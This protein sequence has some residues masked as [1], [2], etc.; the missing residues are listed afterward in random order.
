MTKAKLTVKR[1][2]KL[3]AK[4]PPKKKVGTPSTFTAA[5]ADRICVEIAKG[6][7]LVKVCNLKGMPGPHTVRRWLAKHSEFNTNYAHAR[8]DQADFYADQCVD[9]VDEL[10]D[11]GLVKDSVDVNIARLRVDTRK[12]KAAQ[13]N[14]GRWGDRKQID[15]NANVKVGLAELLEQGRERA[16]DATGRG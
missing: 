14:P 9:I 8:E 15:L 7:S 6:K 16:K 3:K 4:T 2:P 12:W 5:K 1:K 13:M 11:S 10:N